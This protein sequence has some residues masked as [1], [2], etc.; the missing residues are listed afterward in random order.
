MPSYLDEKIGGSITKGCVRDLLSRDRDETETRRCSFR[1]ADRDLEDSRELQR[2]AETFSVTC[3]K[4]HD[5][6]KNY[7]D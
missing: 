3:G 5:N 6:E 4:A 7:T 2:L 1:D